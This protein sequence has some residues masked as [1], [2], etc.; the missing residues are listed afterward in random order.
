[1][2]RLNE[3]QY[4]PIDQFPPHRH[5]CK[6]I[7]PPTVALILKLSSSIHRFLDRKAILIQYGDEVV[8]NARFDVLLIRDNIV[9]ATGSQ[10]SVSTDYA[11]FT[12]HE[13]EEANCEGKLENGDN[14]HPGEIAANCYT[15][16]DRWMLKSDLRQVDTMGVARESVCQLL[17]P[18]PC[19]DDED[20]V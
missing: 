1:M 12:D 5:V 6:R 14:S 15:F 2:T 11:L 17:G 19:I 3:L 4:F 16:L 10:K 8:L 20:G 9:M 18:C 7:V 13:E